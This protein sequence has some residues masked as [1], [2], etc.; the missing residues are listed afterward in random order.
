MN[1]IEQQ[2]MEHFELLKNVEASDCKAFIE[3]YEETLTKVCNNLL[4]M[5]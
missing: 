1:K 3:W 4:V 5:Y 2:E